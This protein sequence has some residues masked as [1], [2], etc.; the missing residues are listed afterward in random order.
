MFSVHV[1]R[2]NVLETSSRYM[3]VQ[4]ASTM[5]V[6]G[7]PSFRFKIGTHLGLRSMTYCV[8]TC[9]LHNVLKN[10]T[11]LMRSFQCA[12]PRTVRTCSRFHIVQTSFPRRTKRAICSENMVQPCFQLELF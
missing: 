8:H 5:N 2:E 12:K 7:T 11:R 9:R 4:I 10:N 6:L 3:S 1:P